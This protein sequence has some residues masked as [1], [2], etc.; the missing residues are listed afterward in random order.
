MGFTAGSWRARTGFERRCVGSAKRA[1]GAVELWDDS[2]WW[3]ERRFL[4]RRRLQI[5]AALSLVF[6]LA[7]VV[8]LTQSSTPS[9][10]PMNHIVTVDLIAAL[11]SPAAPAPPPKAI[12]APPAP[13]K[14]VLPKEAA[15]LR[16]KP[17]KAEPAKPVK[18][19]EMKYDDA[20]AQLREEMGEDANELEES[21]EEDAALIATAEPAQS[22]QHV[23]PV[24]A[25][26]VL[27]TKRH[28]RASFVTPP[29]FL[30][31]GL[32]TGLTVRLSS[33]GD[34]LGTPQVSRSS[35]D[36][37]WDDNS[38]RAVLKASPLP[39]PPEAGIWSFNFHSED[40]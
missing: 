20:L 4:E 18:P 21:R 23:D 24:L 25:A 12:P 31:R 28:V 39:A 37:Y 5:S 34:I 10:F 30:D 3:T 22:G 35:G 6:H 15:P 11:P 38:I 7:L 9:V 2:D 40:R 33:A 29:E 26:W 27:A 19:A 13:K 1:R 36:P 8:F 17:V 14:I 16:K 32:V